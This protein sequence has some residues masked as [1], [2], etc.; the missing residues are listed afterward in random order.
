MFQGTNIGSEKVYLD[1]RVYKIS[2]VLRIDEDLDYIVFKLN[3]ATN[4]PYLNTSSISPKLG[5]EVFA[6]GNSRGLDKTLSQG[7]VSQIRSE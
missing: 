7:I 2:D 6:I 4:L 3:G 1:N 5:D